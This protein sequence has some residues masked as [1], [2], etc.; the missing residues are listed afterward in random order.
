MYNPIRI[1]I[2]LQAC[3]FFEACQPSFHF[4]DPPFPISGDISL[5]LYPEKSAYSSQDKP[6]SSV[7]FHAVI[8]NLG[9]T[10]ITVAHPSICMPSDYQI[11]EIFHIKDRHGKS[12]ILLRVEKPDGKIVILRDGPHFFDPKLTDRFLILPGETAQFSLGWFF[13][14]ARGRWE[15]DL[16]AYSLFSMKGTYRIRLLYRN[17]YPK[18]VIHDRKTKKTGF[19]PVWTGEILSNEA[20]LTIK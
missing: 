15:D 20:V 7:K 14:N 19:I 4:P 16:E 10:P 5:S 11:D 2:L 6:H 1:L 13:P 3:L 12:E 17:F 9:N 18:A 8:K